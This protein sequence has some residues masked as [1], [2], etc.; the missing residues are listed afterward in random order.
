MVSSGSSSHLVFDGEVEERGRGWESGHQTCGR[1]VLEGC[2][3]QDGHDGGRWVGLGEA[4]KKHQCQ[5]MGLFGVCVC[6]C[7]CCGG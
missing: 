6:V 1:D 3:E 7:V 5:G 4:D 2:Q